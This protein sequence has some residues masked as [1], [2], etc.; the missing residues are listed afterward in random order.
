MKETDKTNDTLL[1][2]EKEVESTVSKDMELLN[3]DRGRA[4]N[5]LRIH[6]K[7]LA[8]PLDELAQQVDKITDQTLV[9]LQQ[10]QKR[11]RELNLLLAEEQIEDP[12]ILEPLRER[13]LNAFDEAEQTV[14]DFFLKLQFNQKWSSEWQ[15]YQGQFLKQLQLVRVHLMYDAHAVAERF[16]R[17]R[18][19]LQ[20]T[21][22]ENEGKRKSLTEYLAEFEDEA[23][24]DPEE[25]LI[26]TEPR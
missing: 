9:S 12:D 2:L 23:L 25:Q 19:E 5:E 17:V 24:Q 11:L 22:P 20:E 10:L 3:H 1:T 8:H 16:A 14:I 7:N 4:L 21:D 15:E 18:R 6:S 26:P 13:I